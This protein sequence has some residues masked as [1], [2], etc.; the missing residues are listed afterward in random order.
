MAD[1][2]MGQTTNGV[3]PN[4]TGSINAPSNTVDG[5]GI[6]VSG[7]FYGTGSTSTPWY[8]ANTHTGIQLAG[9]NAARSSTI[10]GH[11]WYSG[12]RVVPASVGMKFVIKY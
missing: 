1:E 11:G 12:E 7:A 4:I 2:Y 6:G 9:F 8:Y 5:Q 3:L 10:Y